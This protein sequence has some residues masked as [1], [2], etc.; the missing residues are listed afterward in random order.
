MY[1]LGA[2]KEY[3]GLPLSPLSDF[4]ESVRP[5]GAL[6]QLLLLLAVRWEL[7]QDVALKPLTLLALSLL[8]VWGRLR[9]LVTDITCL[10]SD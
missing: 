3:L 6:K 10:L 7:A 9:R 5:D 4:S 1:P 2:M 8:P